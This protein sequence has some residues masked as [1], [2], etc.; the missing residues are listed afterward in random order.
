MGKKVVHLKLWVKLGCSP[1]YTQMV[2]K[3]HL[4]GQLVGS[5]F[6][7]MR[8]QHD[9]QKMF[10]FSLERIWVD[11][12]CFKMGKEVRLKFW[13]ELGCSLQSTQMVPTWHCSLKY[14]NGANMAL[15]LPI[16]RN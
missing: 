8:M 1:R 9:T 12:M 5:D 15:G 4:S 10:L 2:P 13:V 16:G 3:W 7:T 11:S 14:P 6:F